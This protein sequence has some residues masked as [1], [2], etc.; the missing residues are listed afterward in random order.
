MPSFHLTPHPFA[1]GGTGS[2]GLGNLGPTPPLWPVMSIQLGLKISALFGGACHPKHKS[3][4][5]GATIMLY[6]R[7]Q[8]PGPMHPHPHPSLFHRLGGGGGTVG[9]MT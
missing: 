3:P 8:R 2:F 5:M 9:H 1:A 6:F 7:I 4:L